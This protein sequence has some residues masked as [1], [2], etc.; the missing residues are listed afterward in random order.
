S[1]DLEITDECGSFTVRGKHAVRWLRSAVRCCAF[2]SVHIA[3][4][5]SIAGIKSNAL[6]IVFE[7]KAGEGEPERFVLGAGSRR[8]R[9]GNF[10]VIENRIARPPCR[11]NKNELVAVVG[12]D[13]V[14]KAIV[15]KPCRTHSRM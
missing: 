14:R 9:L 13:A 5:P 15:R 11:I 10:R 6:A 4:P 3:R 12:C 2:G 7:A 1:S 8:K